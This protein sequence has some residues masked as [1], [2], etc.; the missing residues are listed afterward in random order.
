MEFNKLIAAFILS[1]I[2]VQYGYS[3]SNPASQAYVDNKVSDLKEELIAKIQSIPPGK[4]GPQGEPGTRGDKGDTGSQ[5]AKGD[6]GDAGPKGDTGATGAQGPKGDNGPKGD[7]GDT[8]P[9]GAI[10][11]KGAAG[12]NG[13]GVPT[14]GITGQVLMKTAELDYNTAWVDPANAGVKRQAGD[15]ALGG[16]I[17][18]V[19]D[20]G[21]H[22]LIVA[23]TNQN[24]DIEW[25]NA[26][27][28]ISNPANFDSDG[29]VY[30]DW[31]LPTRY[32]LNL[33]YTMRSELSNLILSNYW[34]ITEKS[35]ANSYVQDFKTGV[36][37]N[38]GKGKTAVIRAVRS[39]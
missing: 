8:G 28:T 29:K 30:N 19:N 14:G 17:I 22:G 9:Q 2:S 10:G 13:Q 37:G 5:G 32:E 6:K 23:N 25:W 38:L 36:Q 12:E 34:S 33:M 16:T 20:Q 26:Q 24:T 21:T 35:S 1:V 11:A 15:K 18:Y 4:Q 39:F 3:K 31:R 27:D 7:R